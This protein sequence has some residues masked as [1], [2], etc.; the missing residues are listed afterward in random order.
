MRKS[1]FQTKT[2]NK[3]KNQKSKYDQS[4]ITIPKKKECTI[5]DL[6]LG[7]IRSIAVVFNTTANEI[8]GTVATKQS[9]R[10]HITSHFLFSVF[11]ESGQCQSF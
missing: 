1:G 9:R 7:T 2:R 6:V 5:Q 4:S 10:I 3:A 8:P 11:L